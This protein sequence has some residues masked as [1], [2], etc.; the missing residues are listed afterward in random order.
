M[1]RSVRDCFDVSKDIL[2][3]ALGGR[4]IEVEY[5]RVSR[6]NQPVLARA[7]CAEGEVLYERH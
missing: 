1:A 3:D 2:L 6:F 5:W 4:E 7:H